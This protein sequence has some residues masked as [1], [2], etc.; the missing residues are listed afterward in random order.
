M[1]ENK[2]S[3]K[4]GV[5]GAGRGMSIMDFC[6]NSGEAQL[7]AV[8]D[9]DP[10]CLESARE[11][12]GD[13]V[14]YFMDFDEFIK[15]DVD[16]VVLANYANAHAPFA[17]KALNM[18]KNVLSELLPVQTMK[19]AVELVEAAEKSAGRY[20]YGENCCFMKAP[21]TM[22]KMFREGKMGEFQ[23]GEGE[24]MH[25]CEKDWHRHCHSD[26]N[27]WRNT[28]SAF[29]YCTHSLGPLIHIAGRRPV[30]VTGFEAPFNKKMLRMGA[31]AGPF[32]VEMVTL[33]N[34]AIIKSL[35]GVGPVKYS[36]WFSAQGE[37]G[38][39]ESGR[40]ITGEGVSK[41]Y[42]DIDSAEGADDSAIRELDTSDEYD[43][44]AKEYGH[45]GAD[46]YMLHNI[47][48]ALKGNPD[49]EVIELY[50]ALDMFLPGMF[51]YF[52]VLEG[53][54][55]LEIPDLRN[56]EERVKYRNDTRCT[57]P[58]VAG[59]MLIPSYSKG[60]PDIPDEVYEKLKAKLDAFY[61]ENR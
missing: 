19:E 23:Y 8:C 46:F 4:F 56:K 44:I 57:D 17:I 31:K 49:A 30:S 26:P 61:K 58:A 10:V 1:E 37:M 47:C 29:Y 9:S 7:A 27:H 21:R 50:E 41:L 42:V 20:F 16:I 35:H 28:M 2:K 3:I 55:P 52:S 13:D 38:V 22:A 18:G 43:E 54:K 40:N 59:D 25:N 60:N 15:C 5:L 45:D 14:E 6:K 12:Y 39:M 51:A 53:N 24:Y 48:E 34:G 36:L 32:G 11:K 33:D